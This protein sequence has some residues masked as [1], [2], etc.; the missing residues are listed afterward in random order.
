[1]DVPIKLRF[2]GNICLQNQS[3][4]HLR[5]FKNQ[6]TRWDRRSKIDFAYVATQGSFSS[7]FISK[8]V[9]KP[10]N[11]LLDFD[12]KNMCK[13]D[14]VYGSAFYL[15]NLEKVNQNGPQNA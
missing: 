14:L 2:R 15:P 10:M 6:K 7:S 13:G 1:M 9:L 8:S 12:P 5:E 4:D 11:S 3:L